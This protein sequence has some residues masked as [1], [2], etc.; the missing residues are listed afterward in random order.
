MRSQEPATCAQ[1]AAQGGGE[2]A[3]PQPNICAVYALAALALRTLLEASNRPDSADAARAERGWLGS[4]AE[5]AL[6]KR[7]LTTSP[8]TSQGGCL[9][10]MASRAMLVSPPASLGPVVAD[11]TS[12][13][14][15]SV[16]S[17]ANMFSGIF[18]GPRGTRNR[19]WYSL[20]RM[21]VLKVLGLAQISRTMCSVSSGSRVH[22]LRSEGISS[23]TARCADSSRAS[24]T[25]R[26]RVVYV[27]VL[28]AMRLGKLVRTTGAGTP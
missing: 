10:R 15:S 5:G 20:L 28:Q 3:S 12:R 17:L 23:S 26:W 7:E 8:P 14:C 13:S 25:K 9:S 24:R 4:F 2:K 16:A 18:R 21:R 19:L 1:F 22:L 11:Q 27:A 6:L